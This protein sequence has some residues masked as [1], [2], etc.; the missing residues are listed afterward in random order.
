[1]THNSFISIER[2][3]EINDEDKNSLVLEGADDTIWFKWKF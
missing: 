1:M 2:V 3:E